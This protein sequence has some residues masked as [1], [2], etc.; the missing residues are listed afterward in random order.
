MSRLRTLQAGSARTAALAAMIRAAAG[1]DTVTA[2]RLKLLYTR[3]DSPV[4]HVV[5]YDATH[6]EVPLTPDAIAAIDFLLRDG[7]DDIDWRVDHDWHVD[8]GI[9]RRSPGLNDRGYVP[10]DDGTLGGT[11]P[12]F[13]AADAGQPAAEVPRAAA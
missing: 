9:L 13:L 5:A 10:H 7:R 4:R 6:W 3:H 2:V 8:T 11:D 12:V 1:D